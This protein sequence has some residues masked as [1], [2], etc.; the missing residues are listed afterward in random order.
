[1]EQ[2]MSELRTDIQDYMSENETLA[3]SLT[4]M[5]GQTESLQS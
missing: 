5:R 3:Q 4:S 1:M 2:Q